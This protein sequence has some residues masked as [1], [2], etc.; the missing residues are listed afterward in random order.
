M[1]I[2]LRILKKFGLRGER[3]VDYIHPVQIGELLRKRRKELGLRLEDLADDFISPSTIS[4]IE[5][6]ITYVNEEKI[7]YVAEKLGI[8]LNQIHELLAKEKQEENR[9]E[10]KLASIENMIDLISP[11]RGL[12]RLRK[13]DVP[14]NHVLSAHIHFLRGKVYLKKNNWIKAQNHFLEA[15]RIVDQKEEKLKTNIK[16]ASYHE[17]SLIASAHQ[18]IE[19]ALKYVDEGIESFCAD[20]ERSYYQYR[21]AISRVSYLE[22]LQRT[23]EALRQIHDLWKQA[24]QIKSVDLILELYKVHLS[25]LGKLNLFEEAIQYAMQGIEVARINKKQEQAA[26][27]WIILGCI[28]LKLKKWEEGEN[29]FRTA[30]G[31]QEKVKSDFL[32]IKA[33][34]YLGLLYLEQECWDQAEE[35]LQEALQLCEKN[36]KQN[37]NQ[38]LTYV[39]LGD[40]YQKQGKAFEAISLY[41]KGLDIVKKSRDQ[42]QARWIVLKMAQCYEYVN[43]HK[44]QEYLLKLYQLDKEAKHE[45]LFY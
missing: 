34:T 11:D 40:C 5:R 6:G 31:L 9:M 45:Y 43:E 37:P 2:E 32:K 28:Y 12:E 23:E 24:S 19:Q 29:C 16:A 14:S 13:L 41:E 42:H 33:N 4:N 17:L 3:S 44:F 25:I 39:F 30:L 22:K 38:W 1:N 20:G 21:L 35:L 7:H 27:L 10:L 18:D 36:Q 15:I 8:N 26:E